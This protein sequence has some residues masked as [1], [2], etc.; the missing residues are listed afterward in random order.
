MPVEDR[1]FDRDTVNTAQQIGREGGRL[2]IA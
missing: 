1:F 2:S